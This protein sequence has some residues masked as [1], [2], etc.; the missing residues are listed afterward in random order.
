MESNRARIIDT[1]RTISSEFLPTSRQRS[2]SVPPISQTNQQHTHIE[3]EETTNVKLPTDNKPVLQLLVTGSSIVKFID[4]KQIEKR[5]PDSSRTVCM[6][7]GKIPD[8]LKRLTELKEQYEIKKMI[9]HVGANHIPNLD[10]E[11]S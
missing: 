1:E 6:P 10:S 4:A 8:I 2:S 3:P 7:G 9:V 5:N 11:L